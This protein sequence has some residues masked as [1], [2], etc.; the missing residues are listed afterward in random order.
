MTRV[1][2]CLAGIMAI[3]ISSPNLG[4]SAEAST[5]DVKTLKRG[6]L[7]VKVDH[8]GCGNIQGLFTLTPA[9]GNFIPIVPALGAALVPPLIQASVGEFGS[10]L[11]RASGK[12]DTSLSLN[13]LS[14][15]YFYCIQREIE[16][17]PKTNI[18]EAHDSYYLL[19]RRIIISAPSVRE[20]E[21][22]RVKPRFE[23]QLDIVISSDGSAFR[24]VPT[25]IAYAKPILNPRAYGSIVEVRLR[26][27]GNE[28]ITGIL[29]LGMITCGKVYNECTRIDDPKTGDTISFVAD[30][31]KVGSGWLQ[32]PSTIPARF[33]GNYKDNRN[34]QLTPGS[35]L[36]SPLTISA[37]LTEISSYDQFLAFLGEFLTANKTVIKDSVVSALPPLTAADQQERNKAEAE[38]A[39]A[40]VDYDAAS[41]AYV[42]LRSA[43]S[44]CSEQVKAWKLAVTSAINANI[45]TE[46]EKNPPQCIRN[47]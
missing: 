2:H 30:L 18:I 33:I 47:Q 4:K 27:A 42:K 36:S 13:G 24:L 14:T 29:P 41:A 6:L 17:N 3:I 34:R 35:Y 9:I 21:K 31:N 8:N 19:P 32:L 26:T 15:T 38:R 16:R 5:V 44:A 12:N 43:N 45:I 37:T 20:N 25:K 40:R 23:A 46:L 10:A 22:D 11:V 7:E 39:V 1:A 28:M